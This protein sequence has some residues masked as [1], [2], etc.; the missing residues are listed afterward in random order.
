MVKIINHCLYIAY[1]LITEGWRIAGGGLMLIAGGWLV[2]FTMMMI[3]VV[4]SMVP[5]VVSMVVSMV[6]IVCVVAMSVRARPIAMM[7]RVRVRLI[8][9]RVQ[10]VGHV[11]ACERRHILAVGRLIHCRRTA[12]EGLLDAVAEGLAL[13]EG[14][15]DTVVGLQRLKWLEEVKGSCRPIGRL[16]VRHGRIRPTGHVAGWAGH[17]VLEERRVGLIAP[18]VGHAPYAP[19]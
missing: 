10:W 13:A 2:P 11:H 6:A 4:V 14:L 7:M 19:A 9:M 5:V 16:G 15:L 18:P 17:G 8:A 3:S 1:W 12:A